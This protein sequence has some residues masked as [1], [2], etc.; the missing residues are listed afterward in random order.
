VPT[1]PCVLGVGHNIVDV[2]D[3]PLKDRPASRRPARR[4]YWI[5]RDDLVELGRGAVDGHSAIE[6]SILPLD[7]PHLGARETH[8]AL[9]ETVQD[10]L[11]IERRAADDFEDL[12]GRGFP[13]MSLA[14]LSLQL[15][16]CASSVP[17][18][19]ASAN[20]HNSGSYNPL[21][22][23]TVKVSTCTDRQSAMNTTFSGGV[24]RGPLG[25]TVY[26]FALLQPR[27]NP[28]LVTTVLRVRAYHV[29][30]L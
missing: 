30:R 20:L 2:D 12:G 23:A 4:R 29:R 10:L 7:E 9:D 11:E 17:P 18:R 28:R 19:P 6:L 22:G 26:P 24:R 15:L 3:P 16:D 1:R 14:Q 27:N 5:P 21:L 25:S 8:R 13:S